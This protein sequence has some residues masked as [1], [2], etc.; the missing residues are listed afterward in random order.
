MTPR[1]LRDQRKEDA[2]FDAWHTANV[3]EHRTPGYAIVN[4]SLK[5]PGI[6]PGDLTADQMDTRCRTGRPLQSW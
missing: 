3:V 4:L 5:S 2:A 1:Q 6:A